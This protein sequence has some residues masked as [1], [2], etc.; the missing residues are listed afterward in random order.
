MGLRASSAIEGCQ[1]VYYTSLLVVI[2][3]AQRCCKRL[4]CFEWCSGVFY[5]KRCQISHGD[6]PIFASRFLKP[7]G[8]ELLWTGSQSLCHTA[9]RARLEFALRCHCLGVLR[10][11]FVAKSV[12]PL[13]LRVAEVSH[14]VT[15]R[16]AQSAPIFQLINTGQ[17]MSGPHP[18]S[19]HNTL[20]T[21]TRCWRP[22]IVG[23]RHCRCVFKNPHHTYVCSTVTHHRLCLVALFWFFSRSCGISWALYACGPVGLWESP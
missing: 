6:N 14:G 9:P 1:R 11:V 18:D 17:A 5:L 23:W 2:G 20:C 8:C 16:H 10:S 15:N 3:V 19:D 21:G 7:V 22:K 4:Y 13:R 12:Q